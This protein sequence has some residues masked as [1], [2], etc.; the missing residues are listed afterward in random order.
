MF[1]FNSKK[2]KNEALIFVPSDN[3][4]L[5]RDLINKC[6]TSLCM[7]DK[8]SAPWVTLTCQLIHFNYSRQ[9]AYFY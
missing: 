9:A 8:G 5:K 6:L 4:V 7:T 3:S 2:I 1:T